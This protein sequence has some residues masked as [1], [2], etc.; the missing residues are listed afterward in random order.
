MVESH[1][2][3]LEGSNCPAFIFLDQSLPCLNPVRCPEPYDLRTFC[4][5]SSNASG[6]CNYVI[7][8]SCSKCY[9]TQYHPRK[10]KLQYLGEY[11][12]FYVRIQHCF[13]YFCSLYQNFPNNPAWP[14]FGCR[15]V[16]FQPNLIHS[17]K[18]LYTHNGSNILTRRT[19]CLSQ[20][21][22]VTATVYRAFC[23][24]DRMTK[25]PWQSCFFF[26]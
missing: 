11:F 7:W 17:Q 3:D 5:Y 21:H 13:S 12:G 25:W 10:P 26:P 14:K 2:I 18:Y 9:Q 23:V 22:T 24:S 20:C 19:L 4:A 1:D 8:S 15:S 6:P 16:S